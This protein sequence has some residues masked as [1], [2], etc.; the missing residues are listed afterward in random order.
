[1]NITPLIITALMAIIALAA[2]VFL[3]K[4]LID[5]VEHQNSRVS[6]WLV[7]AVVAVSFFESFFGMIGA[8]LVNLV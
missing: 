2:A 7:F 4:C 1:M 5:D 3:T 8:L 6:K